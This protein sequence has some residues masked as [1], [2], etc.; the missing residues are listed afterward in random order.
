AFFGEVVSIRLDTIARQPVQLLETIA[1]RDGQKA[2]HVVVASARGAQ[3]RRSARNKPLT[4]ATGNHRQRFESPRNALTFEAIVTM[5]PLRQH[6][7]EPLLLEPREMHA[8][9]GWTHLTD[10]R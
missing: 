9:R 10:D 8:R 6:L 5:L 1:Q 7:D 4:C 3:T 2:G